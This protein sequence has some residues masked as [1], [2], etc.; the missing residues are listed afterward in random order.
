MIETFQDYVQVRYAPLEIEFLNAT[1]KSLSENLPT[2]KEYLLDEWRKALADA[3]KIQVPC[4]HMSI[5][6]LNISLIDDKPVLQIDF[7]DERW[8]YGEPFYRRRS[9][10]DFLFTHW[11]NF[12]DN[13]RDE[14]FFVRRLISQAEIKSLFPQTLDKLAFLFTCFVKYF[15]AELKNFE[16]FAALPKAEKFYVTCGTYFDWQNRVY[17]VLPEIDLFDL[18][19]NEDTTFRKFYG[20]IYRQ[21]NFRDLNLRGCLF[22]DCLFYRCEL[23]NLILA[24]AN[25]LR[26]R[27]V[28]SNFLAVKLAGVEF[29]ACTFRDCAFRNSTVNPNAVDSDEYFA[30]LRITQCKIFNVDVEGCDFGL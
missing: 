4:A 19:E 9:R 1:R 30:P 11:K 27:F 10:A 13:A 7:Y 22:E 17:A 3:C 12:T 29:S 26:C 8:I 14:K 23:A 25:F 21:K 6:L 15:A 2:I 18:D 24:D 5:S 16:E 28:S 20:K